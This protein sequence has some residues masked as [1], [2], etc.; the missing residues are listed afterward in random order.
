MELKGVTFVCTSSEI[1]LSIGRTLHECDCTI[2]IYPF[3]LCPYRQSKVEWGINYPQAAAKS[4][5]ESVMNLRSLAKQVSF[6]GV[7]L[8]LTACGFGSDKKPAARNV[9][10]SDLVLKAE[11][12]LPP[13]Q[14]GFFSVPGQAQGLLTGNPADY[15]AHV[16]DQRELYWSFG[17]KPAVLGTRPGSPASPKSGVQ[18]YRD[19]YGVPIIYADTVR[20]LWFGVGHAVTTDRLFLLDAVRRTARGSLAELTGC[21]AVPA[22]LQQ[23]VVGYT[24]AEYQTFLEKLSPDARDAVLGYV[25]GANAR[26]AEVRNNPTLLPAE[27]VL[28]SSLP[29][30]INAIDVLASGVYIT[31]FVAAEGGNEFQNISMLKS[32]SSR[33]GSARAGK[34]AFLDLTWLDDA[35]A[36]VSVPVGAGSFS[37]QSGSAAVRDAAFEQMADWAVTLP[38]SLAQGDGTGNSV[39]PAPCSQPSLA[40]ATSASSGLRGAAKRE[41]ALGPEIKRTKSA[42]TLAKATNPKSYKT[43]GPHVQRQIALALNELRA[44]L[45]GGSHAY[46]VGSSRTRDGGTLLVS[47]P[48]LGYDYPLLL[49]EYEI[50]GAGYHAR[51]SS[52]PILPVVGIGYTEHAAWGL[53]TG[54]SK[55]IDSFIETLC[56]TAQQAAGTCLADQYFHD[57]K[58]K[59][60]SCRNETFKFRAAASG[61][62]VGPATLSQTNKICRTVHGPLVA[63]DD[64]K[65]MGRSVAYAMWKREIDTIE[66]IRIWNKARS[67]AEFDAAMRLVTWNENT[68]VATRDGHIAFYHPGLHFQRS[69]QTDM[70]FPIPG[71]GAF[72]HAGLLP[73]EKTPQVRD[74]EEGFL[75]NWN[76]KPAVGW[77]DGE[78][79]GSTSR[80]GGAGQRVTIILDK[81]ATRSDWAFTDLKA[82]DEHAGTIDPRAREYLPVLRAFRTSAQAQL[83]VIEKAALDLVLGWNRSHYGPNINLN[84]PEARDGAAATIFGELVNALRDELFAGLKADVLAPDLTAFDRVSGVGSH[85]FDQSV[86]DNVVVRILAP[87][88]STI[89]NRRDWSGGRSRDAIMLAALKTTL[90]RLATSYNGGNA[91]TEADLGKCMRIHPRSK[92]CSLTGVVGPGSDT[93]PG[94]SCVT[95]PYQDRGSWV[96]RVGYEKR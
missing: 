1:S 67:F 83:N 61:V 34:D 96:H 13:G 33:L 86:M 93:V 71:T 23:R 49:V 40:M 64:A 42:K 41:L 53:T 10:A 32:L 87:N 54:Y 43:Y 85:V 46:A 63:R 3:R 44:Y 81:L 59:A 2:G 25:D 95:M 15:G 57:G 5:L 88:T 60:M 20:D 28:L 79:L 84:D 72:D 69:P 26:I 36:A 75:A 18:V 77:L 38:D 12:V 37:N 50:H 80:P 11:T 39:A 56:S 16:D 78:G 47:G 58:W 27:Y 94:T 76:N 52:V 91:L 68:T 30:P 62:P 65:G 66:G 89:V 74:P 92:I 21:G 7:A 29:E 73:F 90:A 55:T 19:S 48:Q 45:H 9:S 51:G 14:S 4:S 8:A 24:E 70:R 6:Y 31:R 82:L 22:D 17:A 35:K